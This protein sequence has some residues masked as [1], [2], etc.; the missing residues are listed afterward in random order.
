MKRNVHDYDSQLT[1]GLKILNNEGNYLLLLYKM[2]Y[3]I[4]DIY[5]YI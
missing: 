4:I 2:N 3:I 1:G 5:I